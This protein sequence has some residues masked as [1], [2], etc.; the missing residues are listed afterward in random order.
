MDCTTFLG[1]IWSIYL[2]Y[3]TESVHYGNPTVDS[4]R[5][6]ATRWRLLLHKNSFSIS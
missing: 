2:G 1:G 4:V 5:G 3:Y 6:G